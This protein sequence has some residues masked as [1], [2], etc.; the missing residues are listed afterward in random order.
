MQN[1]LIETDNFIQLHKKNKTKRKNNQTTTTQS[2][3]NI[4]VNNT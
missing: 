1:V 2:D 4:Q 3:E